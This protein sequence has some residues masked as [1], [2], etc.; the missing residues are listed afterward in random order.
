MRFWLVTAI[1]CG[2]VA[3]GGNENEQMP[4][5]E[6]RDPERPQPEM[7]VAD[8]S[9]T[10]VVD[11]S[12]ATAVGVVSVVGSDPSPQVVLDVGEGQESEQVALLGPLRGELARLA[13]IEIAVVGNETANPLG[14]SGIAI[15]VLEYDVES[16]NGA[17]AFLGVLEMRD[18]ELWL[19]RDR[20]FKL[21]AVPAHL[22]GLAGATV[23]I[24]GPLD[25][26][27]LRV[28][29]FGIVKER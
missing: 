16:V 8:E 29:S 2:L 9:G 12:H 4:Q 7:R 26:D 25:R 11:N 22:E 17:P 13:G 10:E 3:C 20:S 1:A 6:D 19:D 27:E 21:T 15:E 5:A 28:Q 14:G 18:G 24:A 23:W